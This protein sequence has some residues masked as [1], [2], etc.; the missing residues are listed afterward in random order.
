MDRLRLQ[1]AGTGGLPVLSLLAVV[2]G[3]LVGVLIVAF[4]LYIESSQS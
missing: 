1:L 2:S 4:R 3:V